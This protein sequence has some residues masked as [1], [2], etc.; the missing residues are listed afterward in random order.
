MMVL[1][2][3]FVAAHLA[4]ELIDQVIHSGIEVRMCTF[5][6]QILTLHVDVAFGPL[7]SFFF[8]LFFDGEEDFDIHN[9]V[10]MTRNAIKLGGH[11]R[12]QGGGYFQMV[13]ADRQIHETP[14]NGFMVAK[15]TCNVDQGTQV[16]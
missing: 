10:E 15:S 4:I 5:R 16:H 2:A 8:F 12:A 9:L 13:T 14:P 6:K 1:N 3:L 7:S 11:V